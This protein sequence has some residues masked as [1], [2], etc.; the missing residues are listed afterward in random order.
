MAAPAPLFATVTV[1]R[2]AVQVAVVAPGGAPALVVA[3]CVGGT[4][5]L[6]GWGA[7]RRLAGAPSRA[8]EAR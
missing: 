7:S 5:L 3:A 1:A 4:I 8:L 6:V 2:T